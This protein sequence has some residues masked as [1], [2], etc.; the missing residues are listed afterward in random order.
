[1]KW[2][3]YMKEQQKQK[4]W[5][6]KHPVQAWFRSLKYLPYR[7]KWKLWEQPIMATKHG[8]QR[9]FRGYDDTAYWGLCDYITDIALPV[10][11]QYR[12]TKPGLPW[13]RKTNNSHTAKS[14]DKELSKMITAFELM[15]KDYSYTDRKKFKENHK[16]VEQGLQTFAEHFQGLWD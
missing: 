7:L 12:K 13:N 6:K 14:W 16:K 1:M 9:M 3:D 2:T 5:D 4:Q 11:K 10:L 15:K 8:F